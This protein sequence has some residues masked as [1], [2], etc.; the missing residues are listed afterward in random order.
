MLACYLNKRPLKRAVS[1][2][3]FVDDDSQRILVT[4]ETRLAAKLLGRHV[5]RCTGYRLRLVKVGTLGNP[6]DASGRPPRRE[7]GAG[8]TSEATGAPPSTTP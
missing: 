5:G 7:R 8:K 3:P 6:D 1:T 4:G 2:E